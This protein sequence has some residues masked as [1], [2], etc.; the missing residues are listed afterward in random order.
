MG[1][2]RRYGLSAEQKAEIWRHWKSGESLHEIGRAFGIVWNKL[3][4]SQQ[5]Q[6]FHSSSIASQYR[7]WDRIT[8]FFRVSLPI[9]CRA[10]RI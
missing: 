9:A 4:Q 6:T 8:R 10:W 5:E 7:R 3:W 2:G 1:Q